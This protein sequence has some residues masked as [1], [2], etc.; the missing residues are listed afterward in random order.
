MGGPLAQDEFLPSVGQETH[1]TADLEI[2]ATTCP[3]TGA[4]A[5]LEI[6]ATTC[7]ETGGAMLRLMRI[8]GG[9][10]LE[11][12]PFCGRERSGSPQAKS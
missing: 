9:Q 1:A 5:D 11:L 7:P 6:G 12:E 2:G 10:G 3:E 4:T 8:V